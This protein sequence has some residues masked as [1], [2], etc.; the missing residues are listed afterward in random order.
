MWIT[1]SKILDNTIFLVL[2]KKFPVSKMFQKTFAIYFY[3]TGPFKTS[4]YSTE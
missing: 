3:F 1:P 4:K 2:E